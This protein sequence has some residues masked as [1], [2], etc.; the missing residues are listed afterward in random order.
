MSKEMFLNTQKLLEESLL[1]FSQRTQI[2]QKKNR[3]DIIISDLDSRI[4]NLKKLQS[5]DV[6]NVSI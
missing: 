2:N 6:E 1:E 5:L 4:E 3:L